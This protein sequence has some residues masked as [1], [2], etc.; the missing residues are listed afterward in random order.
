MNEKFKLIFG[1]IIAIIFLIIVIVFIYPII[2]I[3]TLIESIYRR[4]NPINIL[5]NHFKH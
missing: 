3:L 5:H 4:E 2:I 1:W